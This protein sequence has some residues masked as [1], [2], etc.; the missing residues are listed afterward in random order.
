MAE[1]K[2]EDFREHLYTIGK[3]GSRKWVYTQS[4]SGKFTR[5][6]TLVAAALIVFLVALPWIRIAGEQAV[7]LNIPERRFTFFGMT[8]WATDTQFLFLTLGVLG[9]SLFFFTALIGRV[10][11]GWACPETVFL[12]FVFRPIE[13]L[14]EGD[15]ARRLRLDQAPWT[16]QKLAKKGLKFS[17]YLIICWFLSSTALAYFVGREEL[18]VMMTH[19]PFENW[20]LFVTTLALMGVLFFQFG[21]FREQFCTALCPYAR[22][23]SVL[24]DKHSLQ[25]G[26]DPQRGEPRGKLRKKKHAGIEVGDCI[27]C[28]MCVR[29]CPTG[30]DIRNGLQLECIQCANCIDACD[31]IMKSIDRPL[32]LIRYDSEAKLLEQKQT[33]WMRPRIFLY[34]VFLLL[35]STALIYNIFSQEDS[36]AKI[37]RAKDAPFSYVE[38]SILSNHLEIRISNKSKAGQSYQIEVSGDDAINVILPLNPYPVEPDSIA[39][40]PLF[41]HFPEKLIGQGDRA[42][43]IEISTE[44]GY[45]KTFSIPLVGPKPQ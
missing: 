25:V 38:E 43:Q 45:K 40:I 23:Q 44:T 16:T 2:D 10:W 37:L 9:A 36:E 3:D 30:I 32:G 4:V 7:R 1:K 12:E 21:W 26:Y 24:M 35:F 29:V 27:D 8:L 31:S 13:K 17:L 34:A 6:R 39:T 28:G 41:L 14:I 5:Y 15:G 11:C 42:V 20:S 22:F 18:L 19:S 33:H